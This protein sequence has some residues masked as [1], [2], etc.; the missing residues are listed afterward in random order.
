MVTVQSAKARFSIEFILFSFYLYKNAYE[1][2]RGTD[3]QYRGAEEQ[4]IGAEKRTYFFD[5]H[6]AS[7]GSLY[8]VI[9]ERIK[10]DDKYEDK[11]IMI[12]EEDIIAFSKG[13]KKAM[14]F[15]VEK[16]VE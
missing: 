1:Q 5:V 8:L 16:A 6:E 11:R 14:K 9:N 4:Y 13:F 12:F 2:D 7:N 15:L 10:K 3:K